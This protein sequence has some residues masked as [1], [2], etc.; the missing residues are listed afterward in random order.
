MIDTMV[1]YFIGPQV[2]FVSLMVKEIS[3]FTIK[4]LNNFSIFKLTVIKI[5]T[6]RQHY[7][8]AYASVLLSW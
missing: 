6:K 3:C 1:L 5:F 4:P 8:L 2:F 7:I